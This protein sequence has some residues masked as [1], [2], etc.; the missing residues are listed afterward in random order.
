MTYRP[1]D[2]ER[3]YLS[4]CKVVDAPFH[5]RGDDM[6]KE[7]IHCTARFCLHSLPA[8]CFIVAYLYKQAN[9]VC[10]IKQHIHLIF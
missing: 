2:Y 3:V 8:S 6:H 7:S 10:Q 9:Q 5:I 4:S 1:L